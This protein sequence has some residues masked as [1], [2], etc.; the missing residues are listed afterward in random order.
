MRMFWGWAISWGW[1]M[2]YYCRFMRYYCRFMRYYC[3]FMRYYKC[4]LSAMVSKIKLLTVV[5]ML[6]VIVMVSFKAI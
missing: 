3:R 4:S 2:K 6:V 1:F 5:A